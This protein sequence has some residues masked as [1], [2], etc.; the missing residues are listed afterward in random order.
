MASYTSDLTR[1]LFFAF[2]FKHFNAMSGSWFYFYIW[3]HTLC[4]S[5]C[6][7]VLIF[8]IT[9]T[10]PMLHTSHNF[11]LLHLDSGA[12][13]QCPFPVSPKAN[14][15]VRPHLPEPCRHHPLYD[16]VEVVDGFGRNHVNYDVIIANWLSRWLRY[17]PP[18]TF[19]SF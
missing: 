8:S 7:L 1:H 15:H 4:C 12:V 11:Y 16:L 9:F 6:F 2:G 17:E 18:K 14:V 13:L 19:C 10:P 3:I 5:V